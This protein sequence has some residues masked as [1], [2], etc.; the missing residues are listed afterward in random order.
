MKNSAKYIPFVLIAIGFL[1][2][3][4]FFLFIPTSNSRNVDLTYT[5]SDYD[6]LINV[7]EENSYDITETITADFSIAK[8]GIYRYLPTYQTIQC[9]EN[10]KI[11]SRNYK[12]SYKNV[13]CEKL[14]DDY[15]DNEN[16]ILQI[17]DENNTTI[18]LKTYVLSYTIEIGDDKIADFDQFYYN[19]IGEGWD[20]T[21]SNISFTVSFD[22]DITQTKAYLYIGD[23]EE[24]INIANS[25]FFYTYDKDLDP[26]SGMTARVSLEEGYFSTSKPS[27]VPDVLFLIGS[28]VILAIIALWVLKKNNNETIIPVV[29]F[30]APDGITPAEAGY[31]ID[32]IVNK[33]DI[34]SLIVFWANKGFLKI[35]EKD[36][37]CKLVKLKEVDSSFKDF[38]IN[39]FNTLFKKSGIVDLNDTDESLAVPI[40][41]AKKSI[42]Y[43]NKNKNFS[44]ARN[45][46]RIIFIAIITL[47]NFG[48]FAYLGNKLALQNLTVITGLILAVVI[49]TGITLLVESK[50]LKYAINKITY[51]LLN[52][53]GFILILGTYIYVSIITFDMDYNPLMLVIFIPLV[54]IC[55]LYLILKINIRTKEG[56]KLLGQLIGL[57]EFILVTEKDRLKMLVKEDPSIFYEVLPYAYV[58]GVSDIW[59]KIFESLVIETPYWY[60]GNNDVFFGY[61][62]LNTMNRTNGLYSRSIAQ[63]N[64]NKAKSSS[65]GRGFGGHGGGFSGGGFGGG[66]GGSW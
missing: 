55:C 20:T 61:Y 62:L 26:F 66:G 22:K 29:E 27:I 56:G 17:G 2:F 3:A 54:I 65:G 24:E 46:I 39:I 15:I 36:N 7:N 37:D 64:T 4:L 43:E 33:K 34:A 38:E 1:A 14:V 50:E 49:G 60:E 10:G 23:S 59:I 51:T 12:L 48:L 8:H 30:N 53:F 9:E 13:Q 21:I 42:Q 41:E 19:I 31:L 63:F 35:V 40:K 44:S 57:K 11:Y 6:V 28:V 45:V 47:L 5:I 25:S 58:L 16:Y 32:R 18:G 52:L